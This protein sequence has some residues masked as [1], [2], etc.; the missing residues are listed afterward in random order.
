MAASSRKRAPAAEEADEEPL[1]VQMS[2][3][4]PTGCATCWTSTEMPRLSARLAVKKPKRAVVQRQTEG[5]E[6]EPP[7]G[8]NEFVYKTCGLRSPSYAR[9]SPDARYMYAFT[10]DL[11][12]LVIDLFHGTQK[13]FKAPEGRK[14]RYIGYFV[15]LNAPTILLMS[16][17]YGS[18]N[19]ADS[20]EL[21]LLRIGECGDV[22][23]PL[24]E[25]LRFSPDGRCMYTFTKDGSLLFVDL[26]H[27]TQ[28]L[29]KRPKGRKDRYIGY[30]VPLS[31]S[32]ILLLSKVRGPVWLVSALTG[33]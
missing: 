11:N 22:F 13:I 14:N 32:A 18:S 16:K 31:S 17:V 28:K 26:F 33:L 2:G 23:E 9:F 20:M 3:A 15:P 5:L 30:F 8:V 19:E 29:F 25:D 27:G 24:D 6:G 10:N 1:I 12:L 7:I 4:R 21:E